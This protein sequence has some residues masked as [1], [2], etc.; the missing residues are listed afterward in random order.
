MTTTEEAHRAAVKLA[1]TLWSFINTGCTPAQRAHNYEAVET[2]LTLQGAT[3][4]DLVTLHTVDTIVT[5]LADN[6]T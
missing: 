1:A 6:D 4:L 3:H 2:T 5:Q